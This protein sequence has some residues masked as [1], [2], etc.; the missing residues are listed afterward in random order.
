M[1]LHPLLLTFLF[2]PLALA[3][4]DPSKNCGCACCK[5]KDV[6][7][8]HADEASKPGNQA[9]DASAEIRH[10]LRG[11]IVDLFADRS[12]LLVKH[13]EI[14]GYMRAMT[15][16]LKVDAA[17]LAAAIKGQAIVGVLVERRGDY[18]LEEVKPAQP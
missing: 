4:A 13:E 7:C 11:V 14:P 8:C 9:P 16:L 15:M 6:C 18:W 1:K 3:A 17:T 5:G 10:P 12:A 2:A